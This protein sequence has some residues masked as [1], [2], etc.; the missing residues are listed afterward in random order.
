MRKRK[1]ERKKRDKGEERQKGKEEVESEAKT[2]RKERG[3]GWWLASDTAPTHQ[4]TGPRERE[5]DGPRHHL[6]GN[7]ADPQ[8]GGQVNA[9]PPR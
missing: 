5:R 6:C 7:R 9:A 2:G 4:P 3:R 8:V 1:V